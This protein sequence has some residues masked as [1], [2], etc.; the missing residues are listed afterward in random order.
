MKGNTIFYVNFEDERIPEDKII[1]SD[2]I[3]VVKKKTNAEKVLLMLDE[4][5][6]MPEW[7]RWVRRIFDSTNYSL[8]VTGSTSKLVGYRLPSSL[9]GRTIS[10]IVLPLRFIDFFCVL[11]VTKKLIN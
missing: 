1:L 8:I 2:L 5:Q 6:R 4:I 11:R 3:S 9:A 7:S 10:I